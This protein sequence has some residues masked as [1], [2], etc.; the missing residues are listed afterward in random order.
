MRSAER[1]VGRRRVSERLC[2]TIGETEV[3]RRKVSGCLYGTIGEKEVDRR[4]DSRGL[5][6]RL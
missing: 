2:G 1:R 6:V 5:I 3:G 4:M